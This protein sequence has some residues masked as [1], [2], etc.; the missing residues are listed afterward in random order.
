[1]DS[2][3]AAPVVNPSENAWVAE[4]VC[5]T[6]MVLDVSVRT[7]SPKFAFTSA[8]LITWPELNET[9][10]IALCSLTLFA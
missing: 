5:V 1:L 10:G 3:D 9:R 6:V 2:V 8:D 4:Y 7:Q